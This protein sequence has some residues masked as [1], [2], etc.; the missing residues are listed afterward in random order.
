MTL[1]VVPGQPIHASVDTMVS[2]NDTPAVTVQVEDDPAANRWVA[3]VTGS[4]EIAGIAQYVRTDGLVTFVHTEVDPAYEGRGVGSSLVRASLD[5][6]REQGVSV[7]PICPFY[8]R[9][10]DTHSDYQDLDYRR[11]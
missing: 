8:Q 9:W 1:F 2:Q 7:L 4:G 5:A 11:H 10:M 6:V 3:R